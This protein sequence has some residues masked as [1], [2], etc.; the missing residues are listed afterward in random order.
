VLNYETIFS[1]PGHRN[2]QLE[3]AAWNW[4]GFFTVLQ[5]PTGSNLGSFLMIYRNWVSVFLIKKSVF[6]LKNQS[7]YRGFRNSL[8]GVTVGL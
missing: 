4:A 5:K 6:L 3:T 7:F 2:S 8:A 1:I